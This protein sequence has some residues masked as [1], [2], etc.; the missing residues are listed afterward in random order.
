MLGRIVEIAGEG[1]YLSVER[2]FLQISAKGQVL[3]QVPLDDISALIANA[4]GLS[5]SNQVLVALAERGVPVVLCGNNHSPAAILWPIENHHRQAARVDAQL[6]ATLP[7]RKSLWQQVVKSKI[8]MQAAALALYGLPERPL[9]RMA[10]AVKSGDAGNA[11]GQ[12]ARLY[13]SGPISVG[14][15]ARRA[16][17]AC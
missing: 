7:R 2:G 16:S 13:W 1:R 4:H 12:A 3:G 8:R 14:S 6:Y 9:Q 15:G 17:T 5:Y 10:A 11:E